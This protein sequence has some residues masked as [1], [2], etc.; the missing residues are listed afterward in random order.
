M[1]EKGKT[2]KGNVQMPRLVYNMYGWDL[3]H[4]PPPNLERVTQLDLF[5]ILLP[6]RSRHTFTVK[7]TAMK[8]HHPDHKRVE[9]MRR[10]LASCW[11]RGL[12]NTM[13]MTSP[14]GGSC[15][16]VLLRTDL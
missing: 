14:I 1:E 5:G 16:H 7:Y 12:G 4:Q 9:G 8:P 15:W 11:Q 2:K 3:E 13:G 10:D 6:F